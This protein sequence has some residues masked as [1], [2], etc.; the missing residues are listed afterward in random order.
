MYDIKYYDIVM[1]D[2][3]LPINLDQSY[4][5]KGGK[6]GGKGQPSFVRFEG[7][8]YRNITSFGGGDKAGKFKDVVSFGCGTGANGKN[9]CDVSLQDVKF[10]GLGSDGMKS[11][12]VCTGVKGTAT[13]LTGVNDCL[14]SPAPG[15]SPPPTPPAPPPPPKPGGTCTDQL[16]K[17]GALSS[18]EHCDDCA[19]RCEK[20]TGP[21]TKDKV[22]EYKKKH[23][24]K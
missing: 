2:V 11:G 6:G 14:T 7:I 21:C 15:P 18:K 23:C 4:G 9:N 8:S 22:Q 17:C 13:G 1:H 16:K 3:V 5:N 12:M 19:K 20:P 10:E 24:K